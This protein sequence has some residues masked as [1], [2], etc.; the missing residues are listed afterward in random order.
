M[1]KK[2]HFQEGGVAV[3]GDGDSSGECLINALV[4][5]CKFL[6]TKYARSFF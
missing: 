4:C 3:D 6:Y 2:V 5:G 1:L